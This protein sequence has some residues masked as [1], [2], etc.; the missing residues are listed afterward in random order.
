MTWAAIFPLV[1]LGM[2]AIAPFADGWPPVL[3]AL[4]LTVLVVPAAVYLVVPRL[5]ALS[6]AWRRPRDAGPGVRS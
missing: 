5:L 6:A 2:Y 1:T 3:R 4:L